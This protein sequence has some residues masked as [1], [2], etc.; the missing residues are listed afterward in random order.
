MLK[1]GVVSL[2]GLAALGWFVLGPGQ[3]FLGDPPP[4][5]RADAEPFKHRPHAY[6]AARNRERTARISG[7]QD[8]QDTPA[9]DVNLILAR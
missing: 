2:I 1:I 8:P 6:V 9:I 3:T 5:I 4:M 7:R